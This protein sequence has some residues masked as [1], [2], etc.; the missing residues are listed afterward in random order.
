MPISVPFLMKDP[1]CSNYNCS[2]R[3]DQPDHNLIA[4]IEVIV[5]ATR[6]WS[7]A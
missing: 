4:L 3:Y 1:K 5:I 7:S 2:Y 6:L